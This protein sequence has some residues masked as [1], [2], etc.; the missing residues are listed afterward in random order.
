MNIKKKT[1]FNT[2]PVFFLLQQVI[3]EDLSSIHKSK[4]GVDVHGNFIVLSYIYMYM[5]SQFK[6]NSFKTMIVLFRKKV[7]VKRC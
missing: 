5:Y 3:L 2:S 6:L 7:L 4:L 1:R